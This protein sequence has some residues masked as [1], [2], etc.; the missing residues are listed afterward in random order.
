MEGDAPFVEDRFG[1]VVP[2]AGVAEVEPGEVRGVRSGVADLRKMLC[3]KLLQQFQ[4]VAD[5]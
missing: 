4:A 1:R 3:E 5:G 2:E